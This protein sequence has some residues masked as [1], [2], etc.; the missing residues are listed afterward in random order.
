MTL[1]GFNFWFELTLLSILACLLI[2]GIFDTRFKVARAT[3]AA[4]VDVLRRNSRRLWIL[5]AGTTVILVGIVISPLPG[6]GFSVLGPIGLAI[7]ASE[8]VWAK[9]LTNQIKEK[10]GPLRDATQQLA[11]KTPKWVPI[12]VC[13]VYWSVPT[14]LAIFSPVPQFLIWPT[15]SIM[16]APVF[17]WCVLVYRTNKMVEPGAVAKHAPESC[18]SAEAA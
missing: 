1:Q 16:F 9:K 12:P 7:L 13:L 18:K 10:S 11:R 14:L 6:P 3:G 8:F 5:I 2:Y 17:L 4:A 15:A